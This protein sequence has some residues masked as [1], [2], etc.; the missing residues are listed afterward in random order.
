MMELPTIV[1]ADEWQKWREELLLKEKELSR[2]MDAVS[3]QRRRMPMVAFEK[4]YVFDTP[5][6]P[7][8]LLDLFEGH[9]QLIVYHF[10]M[11]PDDPHRCQGCSLLVDNMAPLEHLHARDTTLTVVAPARLSEILPYKQRMG[12]TV[13]F[14]SAYGTDFTDDCGTGMGFGLSVFLRDGDKV[15][16]T[17]FTTGRGGDQFVGTLRYLDVTP[18]G[19]QE[20]WEQDGRGRKDPPSSWWRVHDEYGE[21][22]PSA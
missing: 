20:E 16:R 14:V 6:G 1:S 13:P 8:T 12:W 3:A 10:M 22:V 5:D 19:R 15:Y 7:R 17:Y 4:S 11:F 9:R 18:M 2:F 21:Y